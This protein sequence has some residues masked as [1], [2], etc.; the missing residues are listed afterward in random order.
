LGQEVGGE[1]RQELKDT[2]LALGGETGPD[3]E[4]WDRI[5]VLRD[6]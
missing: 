2:G 1:V 6:L 4:G 3:L 5:S